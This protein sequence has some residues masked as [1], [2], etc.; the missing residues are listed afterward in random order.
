M[1]HKHEHTEHQEKKHNVIVCESCHAE[2]GKKFYEERIFQVSI[3]AILLISL[4]YALPYF[5]IN[6]L[7]SFSDAF[8]EYFSMIWFPILIGLLIAGLIERFVPKEYIAYYL[9]SHK[10]SSVIYATGLGFLASACSH[11][12]LA[13]AIEL[14]RKGASTASVIAFLLASPWANLPV[15]LLLFGFFGWRAFFFI[16][17]ALLIAIITGYIYYYLDRAKMVE[18][19]N[20]EI[21]KES[22]KPGKGI[23]K[24]IK[25]YKISGIKEDVIGVL[26]GSWNV[27]KAI[28]WWILIGIMLASFARAYVPKDIFITY[29]GPNLLGL[30]VTLALA[31]IIEI[32]SEGSAPLAFEIFRQGGAFG[33]A[34]VFL[35]AG[36]ATD[37]T[38]IGLIWSNIG[39]RAAILLPLLTVPQIIL[40]GYLF[41]V[42][43]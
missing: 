7:K 21:W 8:L 9:G 40:L 12:I 17:S 11:G 37:Y 3:V 30:A 41:N 19:K 42:F 15:T 1:E 27:T 14:Y 39:K 43:L 24:R 18:C 31:T 13:I 5:G 32:C 10:K 35:M 34:F 25:N 4:G 6:V 28:M 38:E 33:N 22:K 26:H 29:F 2:H 36:V 20:H 23:L 16:G